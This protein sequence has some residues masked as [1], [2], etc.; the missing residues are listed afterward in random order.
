MPVTIETIRGFAATNLIIFGLAACS[1]T[2]APWTQTDDS[3]WGAKHEA[4][5]KNIPSDESVTDT[6]LNDPALLADSDEG[7]I[8]MQQPDAAPAPEMIA[9]VEVVEEEVVVAVEQPS[10]EQDIMAMLSTNYAVQVFAGNTVESVEKFKN[11]KDLP[12]L[13]TVKTDRSGSI[14]YVLVDIY[15][16]RTSANAAAAD[17]EIKTGSKP[18]VR[19]LAGLQKIAV[20]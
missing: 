19:S 9:P 14:V 2:P 3:P 17:L 16:D 15:P 18:W 6:S 4:E 13:I 20:Q 8:V 11:S 10:Y 12:D 1:S 7:A 5:A